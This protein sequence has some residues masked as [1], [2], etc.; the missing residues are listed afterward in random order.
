MLHRSAPLVCVSS[1]GVTRWLWEF[2]H[3]IFEI[4]H[5]FLSY[6]WVPLHLPW[7][8]CHIHGQWC[9]IL[10]FYHATIFIPLFFR[11]IPSRIHKGST[12]PHA[13]PLLQEVIR[14][15]D[16]IFEFGAIKWILNLIFKPI[17]IGQPN[18]IFNQNW[19]WIVFN[20]SMIRR[21]FDCFLWFQRV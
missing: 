13:H 2:L 10:D 4:L 18:H 16:V 19:V 21:Y 3:Y 6:T 12:T 1:F 11:G 5:F 7:I 20:Q 14:D 8:S 15:I 17:I 9:R